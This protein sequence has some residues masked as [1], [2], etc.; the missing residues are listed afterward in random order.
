MRVL[1]ESMTRKH[2]RWTVVCDFDG[3]ISSVD[4][5][6][7]LLEI[8]AE[9]D[10]LEIEEEWRSGFIGSRECLS[11]QVALLRCSPDEIAQ[12]AD[13]I[14]IDPEFRSFADFCADRDIRLIVASDGL[15]QLIMRILARHSLGHLP[16]FANALVCASQR[17][18]TIVSPYADADCCSQS[19]TCKCAVISEFLS[20]D[21]ASRILFVGDG[22][23]DFCA[24]AR[25]A[26]VVAAKSKLLNHLRRTGKPHVPFSTFADV[27]QL[28]TKL[29]SVPASQWTT[30]AEVCHEPN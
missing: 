30:Q 3:T 7:K 4:A 2:H 22:Q 26:D 12:F 13:T 6:D 5:T 11:R 28:L 14:T 27:Q 15:D 29:I 23:S 20:E 10:W 19:G 9:R 25:M 18:H 8:Y 16:V 1:G 17:T 24:A 21:T